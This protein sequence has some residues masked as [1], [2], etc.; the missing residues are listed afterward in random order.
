MD[1]DCRTTMILKIS[2]CQN[3]QSRLISESR[4]IDLRIKPMKNPEKWLLYKK[5]D[6][7]N[8]PSDEDFSIYENYK[9]KYN[10]YFS[11][12]KN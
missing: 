10:D 11:Q 12:R 3:V 5:E 8:N 1:F 2:L 7:I 9:K 4:L 6:L